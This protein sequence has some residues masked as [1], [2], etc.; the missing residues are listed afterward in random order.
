MFFF[1]PDKGTK[2]QDV[3]NDP[4]TLNIVRRKSNAS[5]FAHVNMSIP[6]FKVQSDIDLIES[7]KRLGITD[8]FDPGLS[9]FTP[10]TTDTSGPVYVSKAEHA[11]TLEIDEEGVTGAAYTAILLAEGAALMDGQEYDFILDRPFY[12]VVTARDGSVLFAGTVVEP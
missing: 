9:D 12:F 1:L 2:L 3:I 5:D 4:E 8:A 7:L 6:K 11:A 10:L